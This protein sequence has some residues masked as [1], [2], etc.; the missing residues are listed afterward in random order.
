MD[1]LSL[2]LFPSGIPVLEESNFSVNGSLQVDVPCCILAAKTALRGVVRSTVKL[3]PPSWATAATSPC[4]PPSDH[5]SCCQKA[6]TSA[7]LVGLA[8]IHGSTSAFE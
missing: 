7:G 2:K 4:A 8:A 6:A 1:S 5:R 3:T